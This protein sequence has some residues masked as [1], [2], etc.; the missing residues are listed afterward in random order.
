LFELNNELEK[1]EREKGEIISKRYQIGSMDVLGMI[2]N[3]VSLCWKEK[4]GMD[5]RAVG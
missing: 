3:T 2:N 1:Y 4:Y 5:R